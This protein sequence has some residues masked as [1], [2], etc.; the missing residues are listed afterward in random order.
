MKGSVITTVRGAGKSGSRGGQGENK[1]EAARNE[2]RVLGSF[3]SEVRAERVQT[4]SGRA[5]APGGTGGKRFPDR[6]L[7]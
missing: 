5:Q 3:R 7:G 2:R 1:E 4:R 6:R